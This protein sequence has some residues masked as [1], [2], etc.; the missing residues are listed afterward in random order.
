VPVRPGEARAARWA[1]SFS[2]QRP[3]SVSLG[4]LGGGGATWDGATAGTILVEGALRLGTVPAEALL[5]IGP[6]FFSP[7]ST[8]RQPLAILVQFGLRVHHELVH[9]LDGH[10]TLLAGFEHQS[11]SAGGGAVSQDGW[12]G[13]IGL[14]L[15]VNLRLG[16]GR[17]LAQMQLDSSPS[18][19]PGMK[20][21]GGTQMLAGYLLTV[22]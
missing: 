14:A 21:L 5:E 4:L 6:G 7:T 2:Q 16:P 18:Q 8:G 13:R 20:S 3:W 10:A 12:G 9:G 22:R 19:L 17:V 1:S 15:G 11:L